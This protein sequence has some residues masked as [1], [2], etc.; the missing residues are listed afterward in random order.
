MLSLSLRVSGNCK[1]NI[2]ASYTLDTEDGDIVYSRDSARELNTVNLP[3]SPVVIDAG[4]F[5]TVELIEGDVRALSSSR[6]VTT[7]I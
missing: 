7:D 6:V 2:R 4:K 5:L 1:F 3:L